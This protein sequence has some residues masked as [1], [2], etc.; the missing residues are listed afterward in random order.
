VVCAMMED[1]QGAEADSAQA[2]ARG[3]DAA[4]LG[5]NG[6]RPAWLRVRLGGP[7][8]QRC[9][10]AGLLERYAQTSDV[11]FS[12]PAPWFASPADGVT[13]D[14]HAAVRLARR[15]VEL[16]PADL[17]ESRWVLLGLAEHRAGDDRAA[18]EACA[19]A[20]AL[21]KAGG[22]APERLLIEAMAHS[23]LGD[24]R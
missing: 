24:S 4:D 19:R 7:D 20:A 3:L 12:Y 23:R 18:L 22:V 6:W 10:A 9:V 15:A 11:R 8:E 5:R 1:W 16:A 14:P 17:A 13:P 21:P 2:V